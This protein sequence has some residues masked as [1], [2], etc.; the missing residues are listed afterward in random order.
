MAPPAYPLPRP[1][2]DDPG[3]TFGLVCDVAVV[4]EKAGYPELDGEALTALGL[5]L[6][7][8]LYKP[9]EEE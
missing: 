3:L 9:S 1:D 2:G 4:I 5:A 6:F 7:R 8:F